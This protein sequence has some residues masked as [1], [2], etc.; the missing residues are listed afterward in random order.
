M[1]GYGLK[2]CSKCHGEKPLECFTR[3]TAHSSGRYSSCK[4]CRKIQSHKEYIEHKDS[5]KEVKRLWRINNPEKLAVLRKRC[6]AKRKGTVKRKQTAHMAFMKWRTDPKNKIS[7]NVTRGINHSLHKGAKEGRSWESLVGYT[8]DQLKTHLEKRFK[9]GMTW[10]NYGTVWQI[11]H[12]IPISV[13]NFHR[14]EDFDFRICWSLKNLQPLE[15]GINQS[16][17]NKIERP[18]QPSLAAEGG[19]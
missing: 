15:A 10:D 7:H 9:K 4:D 5:I 8:I 12:K 17:N 18:F 6:D 16:K 1:P 19:Y 14:P 13:F 2:I 11:D 3:S